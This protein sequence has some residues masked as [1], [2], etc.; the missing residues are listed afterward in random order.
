MP[1][2]LAWRHHRSRQFGCHTARGTMTASNS[3]AV[4]AEAPSRYTATPRPG[5]LPACRHAR[6]C[7]N[8]EAGDG[9]GGHVRAARHDEMLSLI[10]I[11]GLDA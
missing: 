4:R 2:L 7:S 6:V 8:S 3:A 5:D 11:A 10:D 9:A 1:F